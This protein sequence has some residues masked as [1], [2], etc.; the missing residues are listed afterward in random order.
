MFWNITWK[1]EQ[2]IPYLSVAYIFLLVFLFFRF[3]KNYKNTQLIKSA[4][5][6]KMDVHW[7][8]FVHNMASRLSIKQEVKIFISSI[9]NSPLTIGFLK[10]VI[11]IPIASFNHLTT[12]QIEAVILHELAHIKRADYLYNLMIAIVE[13]ALFFNPFTQLI[14]RIIKKERE[15]NCD[16]W[17]LQFQYN[18][19][20][21]AEA[22]L[23]IAYLQTNP[24]LSMNVS[25]KNKGDLLSRIKRIIQPQ[26]QTF[27]YR[28]QLL[29]LL[30]MT[31]IFSCIAWYEPISNSNQKITASSLV[32]KQ[33]KLAPL[34]ITIDNPFFSPLS[35]FPKQLKEKQIETAEKNEEVNVAVQ[36]KPLLPKDSS[37]SIKKNDPFSSFIN[38]DQ[39]FNEVVP[40][41][42]ID[43][44]KTDWPKIAFFQKLDTAAIHEQMK[45]AFEKAKMNINLKKINEEIFTA[46]KQ[47]QELKENKQAFFVDNQQVSDQ[48]NAAFDQ[49]NNLKDFD[50]SASAFSNMIND[51]FLEQMVLKL[52][53]NEAVKQEYRNAAERKMNSKVL[54]YRTREIQPGNISQQKNIKPLRFL[55][56]NRISENHKTNHDQQAIRCQNDAPKPAFVYL[57][58]N[59]PANQNNSEPIFFKL[60]EASPSAHAPEQI[61]INS[62]NN[63]ENHVIHITVVL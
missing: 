56:K 12:E 37:L 22:L 52:K 45:L 51:L 48:L 60:N 17:V 29:A 5:L 35:F 13:I 46:K 11:L 47:I 19:S 58:N 16:D 40:Q 9:V 53:I 49:L 24:L 26:K 38:M 57:K 36:S 33:E 41:M 28:Q 8:L 31:G 2:F 61:R 1:L 4:G 23:Q 7:R 44:S 14:S 63:E 55:L 15:N 21:Y 3:C 43:I 6:Q 10:P 30:L 62:T 18:A 39:L 42:Q 50:I 59:L 27:N 54:F 34:S 20:M 25:G 32:V